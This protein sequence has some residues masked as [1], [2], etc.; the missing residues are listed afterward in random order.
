MKV[1]IERINGGLAGKI[2]RVDLSNNKVT[3]EDTEKYAKRY[4]GGRAVNN[5]ILLNEIP[6]QTKWSDPDNILIIGGQVNNIG[7]IYYIP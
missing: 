4:I 1:R 3:T 7:L 6:P 5:L 2:L